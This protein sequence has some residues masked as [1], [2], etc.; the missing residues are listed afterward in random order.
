MG[1]IGVAEVIYGMPVSIRE[2]DKFHFAMKHP[3]SQLPRKACKSIPYWNLG[4]SLR[5][6]ISR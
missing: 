4:F 1:V 3:E 6:S 2:C 5:Y